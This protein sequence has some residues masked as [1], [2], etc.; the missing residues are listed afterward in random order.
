MKKIIF[1]ILVFCSFLSLDIKA[2]NPENYYWWG[3]E[4]NSFEQYN[5][6]NNPR[7]SIR[8]IVQ[9]D[10][11]AIFSCQQLWRY[12]TNCLK[13]KREYDGDSLVL[14]FVNG[15]V[16][17]ASMNTWL[18][19]TLITNGTFTAWTGNKP[20]NWDTIGG[21]IT[22]SSGKCRFNT[23]GTTGIYYTYATDKGK[24]YKLVFDVTT[25]TT[26]SLDVFLNKDSLM[27]NVD[28]TG[29]YEIPFTSNNM[30]LFGQSYKDGRFNPSYLVTNNIVNI[31]G[32]GFCP[33]VGSGNDGANLFKIN[34]NTGEIIEYKYIAFTSAAKADTLLAWLRTFTT[35]NL[36]VL[37]KAIR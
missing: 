20:D 11:P 32:T 33:G 29:T 24:E 3:I 22:E 5:L 26:G 14:G 36:F 15:W 28:A 23:S 18:N 21:G 34:R 1:L 8:A 30:F 31:F 37:I 35:S 27:L 9:R 10:Y 7:M 13:V 17:T 19:Q 2:Q 6:N 16:D 4:W 12:A 25:A